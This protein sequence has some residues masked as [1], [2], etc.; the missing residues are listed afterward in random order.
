MTSQTKPVSP[1]ILVKLHNVLLYLCDFL[2]AAS[3]LN[4]SLTCK[5][6][7]QLIN[8]NEAY[9]RL[10]YYKEFTLDEDWRE[11]VWLSRCRSQMA[12]KQPTFISQPSKTLEQKATRDWSHV[13]WRKAYY[14]RLIF[15]KHLIDDDWCERYCNLPV[16]PETASLSIMDISAWATLIGENGRTRM[17]VVQHNLA[18]LGVKPEQLTWSELPLSTGTIGE[19][20]SVLDVYMTD[21]YIIMWCNIHFPTKPEKNDQSSSE[22]IYKRKAIVAWDVRD[23]NKIVPIYIQKDDEVRDNTPL[24][25]IICTCPPWILGFTRVV[26]DSQLNNASHRYFIYNLDRESCHPFGLIYT[27]SDAHIQSATEN[28]AQVI[29]LHFDSDNMNGDKSSAVTNGKPAGLRVHWH[30][31]SFDDKHISGLED[32]SGEIIMPYCDNPGIYGIAHGPGLMM[33]MIYS[34]EDSEI[35]ND[36]TEPLVMMALVRVPDH[37]LPQNSISRH[38]RSRRAG[39][40]GDVVWIQPV[41]TTDVRSLYSQNLIVVKQGSRFDVLSDID[42]K[43]VRQLD[44]GTPCILRPIIGPY[45]YM[46][47]NNYDGFIVNI[48]TGEAF[49]HSAKLQS[50]KKR[51]IATPAEEA[52]DS[53]PTEQPSGLPFIPKSWP[54]YSWPYYHCIGQ[55]GT[56]EPRHRNRFYL[57]SLSYL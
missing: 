40:I 29:T 17:W 4:F 10:R 53:P 38:R 45:C 27:Y 46:K 47:D 7:H 55:L 39:M 21:Y 35:H 14:R 28:Y 41:A 43:I 44:L 22:D 18:P 15:N 33:V 9:W 2:D 42:G 51:C 49:K 54:Y 52:H 1:L 12:T 23:I 56:N 26:S 25:E 8:K 5:K 6:F 36:N 31:Y 48:E 24:P 32:H 16:D 11:G 13:H 57:Y 3:I 20:T 34:A 50:L 37:S 30:S 19:I